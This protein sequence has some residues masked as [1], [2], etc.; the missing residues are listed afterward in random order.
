MSTSGRLE[1]LAGMVLR[2]GGSFV[3]I[4]TETVIVLG[5]DDNIPLVGGDVRLTDSDIPLT[6][7]EVALVTP[8]IVSPGAGV[9]VKPTPVGTTN[10]VNPLN[11]GPIG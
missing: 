7:G 9:I 2:K 6:D 4:G 5:N 3:A 11:E 10:L 1:P 8:T